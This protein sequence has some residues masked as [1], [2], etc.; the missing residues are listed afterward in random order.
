MGKAICVSL[1]GAGESIANWGKTDWLTRKDG[2]MKRFQS[3]LVAMD[4]RL[5]E[6]PALQWAIRLAEHNQAKL[7]VID[8]VPDFSWIMRLAMQND[9]ET[10]EV[11]ADEK[12]RNLESIAVPLREQGIDVTT[13]VLFGKTSFEIMHEVLRSHHDLVV[14]VTKGV[15]SHRP[16]FFGTTSMRLLRKCPCPVWL[17]RADAPTRF[18]RVLAAID[19]APHDLAHSSM[20][21]SIMELGMSIAN[22]ENGQFHVVHAWEL[23]GARAMKSRFKPGELEKAKR[24]VEAEVARSLDKVLSLYEL[25]HRAD[26]V[27]LICDEA[28]PGPA[29]SGLAKQ[30]DIDLI[31]MGTIVRTGVAG[32]LMGNTAEHVLDQVECSVLT[33]K[34]DEFISPVTLPGA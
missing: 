4:M 13:K 23:F 25:S 7:T 9:R 32:A 1:Q 27:H 31:V 2:V 26:R 8:V 3:V 33:I 6:H 15:H 20:N 34:P 5:E 14:R 28:G 21:K 10:R 18:A 12:R 19:P 22:S 24:K 16:G 17:V 29:I 11:L 30:K